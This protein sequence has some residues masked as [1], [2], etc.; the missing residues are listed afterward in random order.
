MRDISLAV[1]VLV[2]MLAFYTTMTFLQVQKALDSAIYERGSCKRAF[3]YSIERR[4]TMLVVATGIQA[5]VHI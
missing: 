3:A 5:I 1:S 4:K 2:I